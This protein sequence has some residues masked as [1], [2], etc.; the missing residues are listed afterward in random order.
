MTSAPPRSHQSAAAVD[1]I[2]TL[3]DLLVGHIAQA[4]VTAEQP[5][6]LSAVREIFGKMDRPAL[7]ALV[8]ELG[9]AAEPVREHEAGGRPVP[10]ME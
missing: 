4:Y 5:G 3:V 1:S 2:E 10:G 9:L 7:A 6:A 8:H